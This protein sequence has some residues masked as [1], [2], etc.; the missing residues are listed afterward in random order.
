M[1]IFVSIA[2]RF[3]SPGTTDQQLL[4]FIRRRF[5]AS[6][7][8]ESVCLGTPAAYDRNF[9]QSLSNDPS[10]VRRFQKPPLP[11]AF[12]IA[13]PGVNADVDSGRE[14]VLSVAGAAVNDI[15]CYLGAVKRVFTSLGLETGINARIQRTATIAADGTAIDMGKDNKEVSLITGDDILPAVWPVSM[16][17]LDFIS[18]LRLIKDGDT[19]RR[20]T[21]GEYIRPLM[22]RISSLAYYYC[23]IEYDLD[24]QGLAGDSLKVL[25][26]AMSLAWMKGEGTLSGIQGRV[27]FSG[28]LQEFL[29]FIALG[30]RFN[31]GKGAAY[32]MGS[33][34]VSTI[35]CPVNK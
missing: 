35:D 23:G 8:A 4:S 31:L 17:E 3:E 30:E 5:S 18:P 29:R 14:L 6:F 1:F 10:A 20:L 24:F 25:T 7:R 2:F 9:S 22:R 11:F 15:D 21:F 28:D 19:L 16:I 26:D 34:L 12:K 33:Y 13:R 27:R 32:G